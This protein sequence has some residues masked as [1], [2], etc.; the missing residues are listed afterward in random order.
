MGRR[1]KPRGDQRRGERSAAPGSL[2]ALAGMESVLLVGEGNFS[3]ARCLC[4][5]RE[6]GEGLV[7][8]SYDSEAVLLRKYAAAGENVGWLRE[9]AVE[10]RHD[11]D[12][13]RLDA[14]QQYDAV[15]FMFPHTGSGEKDMA[16]NVQGNHELVRGFFGAAAGAV[17][18][19]GQVWVAVKKGEPYDSWRVPAEAQKAGFACISADPFDPALWPGYEHCTTSGLSR[20]EKTATEWKVFLGKGGARLFVFKKKQDE[21]ES[22]SEKSDDE[23]EKGWK[24]RRPRDIGSSFASA[25]RRRRK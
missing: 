11:V 9:R 2:E 18:G 20:G 16:K 21:E 4:D 6:R 10:V 24:H 23:E 17:K 15:V 8:T 13:T 1:R 25:K 19:G 5:S 7:A 3:F 22:G 12:A 14:D